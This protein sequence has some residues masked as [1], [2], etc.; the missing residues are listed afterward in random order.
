VAG[1]GLCHED[2]VDVLVHE[3]PE[4]IRDLMTM[5]AISILKRTHPAA[6]CF[7]W[8]EKAATRAIGLSILPT[9]PAGSVSEHY[10]RL[11]RAMMRCSFLSTFCDAPPG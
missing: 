6:L 10:L 1:A 2:A 9:T 11:L 7:R 8:V 4:R 3:G 5:G